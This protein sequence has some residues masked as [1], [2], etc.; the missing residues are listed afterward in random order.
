MLHGQDFL[1]MARSECHHV[2]ASLGQAVS[3]CFVVSGAFVGSLYLLVPPQIRRLDRD[4][5]AQIRWR[6][7]A[8]M[9]VCTGAVISY[10]FIF[11]NNEVTS[12]WKTIPAFSLNVD[13]KA[14]AG[15]LLHTV[16]LYFGPI[17]QNLL[18]V[19]EISKMRGPFSIREYCANLY[20]CHIR[21]II[22]ALFFPT[23]QSERW[24]CLRN[25]VVAPM[26]EEV[27]FR[28]CIV[29]P[30]ASTGM[31]T[32]KVCF[33][34]PL[35]FGIA[36]GHHATLKLRNGERAWRVLLQTFFQFSYTSLFGM[37]TSYAYLRT[38]SIL[39]VSLSHSFCNGMGLPNL[40][41]LRPSSPLNQYRYLLVSAHII[42][43]AGFIVG[44]KS[45]LLPRTGAIM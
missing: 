19:Y 45:S 20:L 1:V 12:T 42:G 9:A 40:S 14:I 3:Y 13:I 21:P 34:A 39:A 24:I 32:S 27:A 43:L 11:C 16:T 23:N 17:L 2:Q 10:P 30:L 4:D 44:L 33:V 15:V 5:A 38:G 22:A 7:M 31:K 35:F 6:S 37:Y 18:E 26:A 28:G 41:F 8:T 25:L 36:H 29:P